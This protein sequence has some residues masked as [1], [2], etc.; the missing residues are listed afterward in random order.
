MTFNQN[1]FVLICTLEVRMRAERIEDFK[2]LSYI[3]FDCFHENL[4]IHF[5]YMEKS[6]GR[7]EGE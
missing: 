4:I 5:N 6:L 2:R 7:L 3:F 1:N